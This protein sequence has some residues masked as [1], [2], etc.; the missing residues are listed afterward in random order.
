MTT[1]QECSSSY[2]KRCQ[3]LL[4]QRKRKSPDTGSY[5]S[6]VF[7]TK[8]QPDIS[9]ETNAEE[10]IIKPLFN[11]ETKVKLLRMSNA[12]P[13]SLI[14]GME[15]VILFDKNVYLQN[16]TSCLLFSMFDFYIKFYNWCLTKLLGRH[17]VENEC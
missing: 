1:A 13:A 9:N 8:K 11:D 16:F 5:Q 14:M 2:R 6:G 10:K 15:F 7:N 4:Q 12:F 3:K 17:S